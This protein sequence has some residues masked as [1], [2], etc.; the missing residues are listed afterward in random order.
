[1]TDFDTGAF[2]DDLLR[3]QEQL[4][5]AYAEHRTLLASLPWSAEPLEGWARGERYSHRGDVSTSPGWSEEE[6][7]G[8]ARLERELRQLALSVS[9][10]PYWLTVPPEGRGAARMDLKKRTRPAA[11]DEPSAVGAA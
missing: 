4:H 8:V 10:H 2:P 9:G 11:A 5:R 6:K 3:L 1:M 7:Q